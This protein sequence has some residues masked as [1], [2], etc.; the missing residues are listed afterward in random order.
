MA[1]VPTSRADFL[2]D[3]MIVGREPFWSV[4][5]DPFMDRDLTRDDLRGLITKGLH[6]TRGNYV[7]LVR[8]FNLDHKDYKRF[9]N[10]LQKHGCHVPVAPFRA[11]AIR[12]PAPLVP[13]AAGS[14]PA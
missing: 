12:R 1:A 4:V 7:M 10:F 3:R 11:G 14:P 5:Y 13:Q 2:Y 9:L 8:L 6:E